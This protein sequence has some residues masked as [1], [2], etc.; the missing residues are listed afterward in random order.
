MTK[1][2]KIKH[3]LKAV[4]LLND[5]DLP[6]S[7]HCIQRAQNKP[8]RDITP[9]REDYQDFYDILH[10]ESFSSLLVWDQDINRR[11]FREIALI[12]YAMYL[13]VMT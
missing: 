10:Y 5:A 1:A 7:C 13:E 6:Y 11:T 3:L 4:T 2:Q 8:V 12:N 9:L